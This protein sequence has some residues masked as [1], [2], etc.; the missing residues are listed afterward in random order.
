M[1]YTPPLT[2]GT[3][4]GLPPPRVRP[5]SRA[6]ESERIEESD[7]RLGEGEH[8]G[9]ENTHSPAPGAE[10]AGLLNA[11][12]K[13][14]PANPDVKA[15]DAPVATPLQKLAKTRDNSATAPLLELNLAS[16]G[17]PNPAQALTPQN[18]AN[19]ATPPAS[20]QKNLGL[21]AV[22][23]SAIGLATPPSARSAQAL[24]PVENGAATKGRLT[25][26]KSNDGAAKGGATEGAT[27]ASTTSPVT[28]NQPGSPTTPVLGEVNLAA[29]STLETFA[30]ATPPSGV[31]LESARAGASLLDQARSGA[32]PLLSREAPTQQLAQHI[33]RRFDGGST[34]I[35]VR[36]DPAELGRVDVRLEVARD[37]T[38]QATISVENP[39]TLTDLVRHARDLERAL[40]DA[41]LVV[42]GGGLSFDLADQRAGQESQNGAGSRA[43][44]GGDDASPAASPASSPIGFESWRR[45]RV[46]IWA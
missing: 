34:S 45:S 25:R 21:N 19:T 32:S 27:S 46:D 38:V 4:I 31:L 30:G 44:G 36:M 11:E 1:S 33:I 12:K 16:A 24:T 3:D 2:A 43:S 13:P 42:G 10:F 40:N 15:P 28:R 14:L 29:A 22:T 9:L 41:G 37:N 26:A 8:S 23:P 5:E 35:E 20:A 39:A 17:T 6:S 7:A 18:A